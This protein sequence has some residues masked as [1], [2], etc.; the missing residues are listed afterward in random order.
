[1]SGLEP[2]AANLPRWRGFNIVDKVSGEHQQR[3]PEWKFAFMAEHGF[4]FARIPLSYRCWA[5]P[6]APLDFD[7]ESLKE[8]DEVVAMGERFGI[9]I[10]LN[11][12]RAPGY[13]V[14]APAEP[15]NLWVD[16]D[17]IHAFAETWGMFAR[18]YQGRP[19]AQLSF[20]LLNEPPDMEPG[21]YVRAMRAAV[22]A[23]RAQDPGRLMVVDGMKYGQDPVWDMVG[24]GVAQS[25]RGYLPMEISHFEATWVPHIKEWSMPSWP[26]QVGDKLRDYAW[27]TGKFKDF[28]ELHAQGVGV[29][30]GEWGCYRFT[31]HDVALAWMEDNLR[32]WKQWGWGWALWNL[33]G[34]FGIIDSGRAD[35]DYEDTPFGPLDR[36]ML[37]LL[38]RY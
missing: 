19:N 31:P 1:M 15:R 9:H 28:R 33:K 8:I 11:I 30:V 20:D 3:F 32:N 24:D 21:P 34:T 37:E 2:T 17:A 23:I 27:M 22:S 25:T 7:E 18:R 6:D 16:E 5:T 13:C 35:V 4:D 26:M 10:N 36:A 29:H 12:H 14:N 38:K